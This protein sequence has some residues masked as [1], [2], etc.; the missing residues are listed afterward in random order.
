MTS[1]NYRQPMEITYLEIL[2]Y[3]FMYDTYF[4]KSCENMSVI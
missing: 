2:Q 3:T 4:Q 1:R